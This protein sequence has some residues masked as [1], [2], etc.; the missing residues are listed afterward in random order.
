MRNPSRQPLASMPIN[1]PYAD[2]A[3]PGMLFA[4]I[5]KKNKDLAVR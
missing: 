2:G 3:G 1:P 4:Y 5:K